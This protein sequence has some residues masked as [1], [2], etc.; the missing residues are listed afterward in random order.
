M[1]EKTRILILDDNM[2]DAELMKRELTK[3]GL[4]F[5]SELAQ[6]RLT[7][8]QA[9]EFFTPDLILAD[10]SLPA[11]DGMN[12]MKIAREK[13][14]GIPVI[15]VS[16][17]VGEETAIEAV[18]GGATDYV[19][20]Q[21]LRRLG[22]VVHRA[23]LEARSLRERKKSEEALRESEARF[24]SVLENSQDVIYRLNMQTGRFEYISPAVEKIVGFSPEELM[25]LDIN[26]AMT[27]IHPDDLPMFQAEIARLKNTGKGELEYRQ[28]MKNGDYCWISNLM[29]LTKDENGR[30]LY[31]NGNVRN[32]NKRKRA[33]EALRKNDE[34]LK[35]LNRTL[36]ALNHSSQ[37]IMR[38]ENEASYLN[39]VCK[40]VC[41][42]CGH[43][44]VWIG[45]AEQDEAK[46]VR[47][48][49]QAGFEEGYLK[50]VNITWADTERGRGPTGLA[51]RTGKP[52][53]CRNML[54]DPNFEP[55][56]REAVKR[57]YASSIV[58]PLSTGGKVFGAINIYS[59]DP[60]P[61]SE[62]EIRLLTSLADDLSFG[63]QAIRL[64]VEHARV[65]EA[66]FSGRNLLQNIIDN[67]TSLIYV[68]DLEERFIVANKPLAGLLNSSPKRMIGK[69]R[70]DFLPKDTAEQHETND[71]KVAK[72]KK[73]LD[74][75][76][77]A[78][79][80]DRLITFLTTKFPLFNKD[81]EMYA[82]AGI[83][84]DIS[85]RK[86]AENIL[87]RDKETFE[88]L[89]QER[90]KELVNTQ[91]ELERSK[92]LSDIGV[93]AATVAH[94]L[95]NPLAAMSM[96][97][98]N[99]RRKANNQDI[100]KH[101]ATI[102]KKV[103]ESDQIINNLLFYSRL[104]SPHYEFFKIS[105]I[106]DECTV[107]LAKQGK[108]ETKINKKLDPIKN[109]QIEADPLQVKEVFNNILNNAVD[110]VPTG[111]GQIVV[112]AGNNE[113]Y[114]KV[115]IEDNGN[116]IDPHNLDKIFDPFFTTKAKGTGLGLSVC[117]QIVNMHGGHISVQTELGKGTAVSVSLP[118]ERR[119]FSLEE[120]K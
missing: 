50:T 82:I 16:G 31:R 11:F 114:V 91:L 83:S 34:E 73:P 113:E 44:M 49:A 112:T 40:I 32:I 70:Q 106:I 46:T 89:V 4:D 5:T 81:G 118:I 97:A 62:K 54:V 78:T 14:D 59:R 42:D 61:F 10:Y 69:K 120:K 23:L 109:V 74:F 98:H 3:A 47:P 102:E 77:Y 80:N 19:L 6:D 105:D 99:I 9:L 92:R 65:E 119:I 60:D 52:S 103:V 38:A 115:T 85:D 36:E 72:A 1:E 63:I 71:R 13:F 2:S 64:R 111:A 48:V 21:R 93:L 18:K 84:T 101:L 95:R 90:T 27:M 58:L 15:I 87:K 55:W 33:E 12:A 100:E 96:A 28:R 86:A 22:P 7:F 94:E 43:A 56:R 107:L 30:L 29:Y 117:K 57:G 41:E 39:E 67:T 110:A 17:A 37:A 26:K 20:K 25:N 8:L 24:R 66:L 104:K 51:I 45:W 88:A 75:E 116:G 79:I 108:K 35:K 76:E 53:I 68:L